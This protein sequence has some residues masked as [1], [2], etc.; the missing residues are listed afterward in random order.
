[1][2]IDASVIVRKGEYYNNNPVKC[3]FWSKK[4]RINREY[5]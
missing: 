4:A 5:N 3:I 1:M 2:L